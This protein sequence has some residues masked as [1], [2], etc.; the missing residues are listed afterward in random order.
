[1]RPGATV[2]LLGPSGCGKTTLLRAI[3]GLEAVEDG[4]IRIAGAVASGRGV[5]VPPQR[6][7]VGMVFQD[8]AL[9]PHL[10]VAQNVAYGLPRARRRDP[11][12]V[13]TVLR[14]VGLEDHGDR[15]PSQL[16]GG[17]QQRVALAR[18][19]APEPAV[20]LLDEP[21]SNLDA[22]LRAG[23]R[24]DLH[25]LLT[26]LGTTSVFV[27]HD[28]EEA[29]V[30]GDEV[31]VMRDGR[32]VQ[33]APPVELYARPADPWVAS[34]VGIANL[35]PATAAGTTAMSSVGPVPLERPTHGDV[36]VLVRP[37]DLAVQAGAD[38]TVERVEYHGHDCLYR[39]VLDGGPVVRVR[40][41]SVP[42][43]RVGDRVAV[44]HAGTAAV[45][46]GV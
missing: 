4:E 20:L 32:I 46:F 19:L 36:V 9:F 8:W 30:L 37:E 25:G 10:S 27:T 31:A 40:V 22:T 2:V 34:F 26:E 44:G 23:V 38:A 14:L 39:V 28:Q 45:A 33:Q 35:L 15:P 6:R 29:F 17:Q 7:R 16:S 41:G 13:A 11:E 42:T 43:H 5:H 12:A 18:A 24:A 3:A 21:F 1:V